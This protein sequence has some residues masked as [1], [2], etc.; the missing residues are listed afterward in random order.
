M[1]IKVTD[2]EFQGIVL[3]G[4]KALPERVRS[5]MKNVAIT[6]ADRQDNLDSTKRG[7]YKEQGLLLGLYEGVPRTMRGSFY[8]SIPDKITIFKESTMLVSKNIDDL[9]K[10]VADTIWHEVAHHFGMD[11]F[12]VRRRE[13]LRES[14]KL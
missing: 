13:S 10:V 12:E 5:Q 2:K 14:N 3:R 8:S 11:E 7:G 1:G 6:I 4:I 9:E